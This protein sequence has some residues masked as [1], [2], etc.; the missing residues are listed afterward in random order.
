MQREERP[1]ES[2]VQL[3]AADVNV[4]VYKD[5]Q[6]GLFKL[7]VNLVIMAYPVNEIISLIIHVT[8]VAPWS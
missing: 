3:V 5:K 4:S 8:H 2:E 6:L 7:E 1:K